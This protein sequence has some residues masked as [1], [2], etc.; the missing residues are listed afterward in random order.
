MS[1]KSEKAAKSEV[2]EFTRLV[3]AGAITPDQ[4]PGRSNQAYR[5]LIRSIRS[6]TS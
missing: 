6:G 2:R 4:Y 3:R 5:L 1:V